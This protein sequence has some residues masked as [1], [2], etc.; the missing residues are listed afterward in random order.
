VGETDDGVFD[1]YL[2]KQQK[3]AYR[4]MK[5]HNEKQIRKNEAEIQKTKDDMKKGLRTKGGFIKF[6]PK[7]I[8]IM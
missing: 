7:E 1:K 6:V 3:E 2:N 4:L 8:D 5:E